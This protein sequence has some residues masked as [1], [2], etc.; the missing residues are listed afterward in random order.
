MGM[1]MRHCLKYNQRH[2][3]L[4]RRLGSL[5]LNASH[6]AHTAYADST[7]HTTQRKQTATQGPIRDTALPFRPC[8]ALKASKHAAIGGRYRWHRPSRIPRCIP[9][10]GW[11]GPAL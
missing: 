6:A 2:L 11:I 3:A 1:Y 7:Q 8:E 4:E 5:C 10:L 9:A